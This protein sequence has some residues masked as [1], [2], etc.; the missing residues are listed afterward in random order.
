M[1]GVLVPGG[2]CKVSAPEVPK[3]LAVLAPEG[4]WKESGPELLAP[5]GGGG[6]WRPTG[7]E[8]LLGGG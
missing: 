5:R 1:P 3:P 7:T 2:G 8:L 6:A 4:G